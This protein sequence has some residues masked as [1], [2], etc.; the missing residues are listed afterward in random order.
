M[1]YVEGLTLLKETLKQLS[2]LTLMFLASMTSFPPA[3]E[4][5]TQEV[6]EGSHFSKTF[7]EQRHYRLIL[8]RDY[9]T[10][11]K[12][13]PVIYYFH[14]HSGRFKGEQYGDG[15]VFLP[16]MIDF[17][18]RHDVVIVRWDGR[19]E[20]DYDGFYGGTPYDIQG[21]GWGMDFG[22][23]FLELVTHIDKTYRTLEDRSHR[24]TS[25]LSMGGFMSLY[26]SARFPDLVGSA[27]A[28]NPAHENHVGPEGAKVLYKHTDHV[29][30][31]GHSKVRLVRASGDYISQHHDELRDVYSRTPGVDFEYRRDE[32]HRHWVT[33]VDETFD[34]H[35]KAFD[36]AGLLAHPKNWSYD[37]A[38]PE[39][40]VWGYDV[41]VTNKKPGY[42]CL[43][44]VGWG[45]FRVFTRQYAPD[46]PPVEEQ[47]IRITTPEYYG[48]H[49]TY[50]ILDYSHEKDRVTRYELVS[51]AGGELVFELDG[52]GHDIA[53]LK[54]RESR[55]PVLLPW[56]T[57]GDPV[58]EPDR[59][60]LLPIRLINT[61]GIAVK[62]VVVS[63]SS[64]YP[65]VE[66]KGGPVT[67]E[68][69]EPGEIIDL[70]DRFT[71]H[72]VSS[73][74]SFQHCRLNLAVKYRGWYS[75][76]Y[77]VDARILPTPLREPLGV[78]VIDGRRRT[79]PIFRQAGNQGGG[80]MLERE[81][82]EGTGNGDGFADPGEAVSIWIKLLQG[83][84]PFDK[85]SWHRTKIYTDDACVV[86][87]EDVAEK[88]GREFTSVR[89][90][91][92]VIRISPDCPAGHKIRLFLK[93]ESYSFVWT[94]DMRYGKEPL[95]QATQRYR[96]HFHQYELVVGGE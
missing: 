23:Y 84:V 21:K 62:N 77:N 13:Y 33:S 47:I 26:V 31:H 69:I 92:S 56:D 36:D 14:G 29:L 18:R 5:G 40:S 27:S 85:N 39:F 52:R 74:G 60:L 88:K 59:D 91:T 75:K 51:T 86:S 57:K 34:F 49:Q 53:I 78:E 76:H 8:P 6:I 81:V 94:P 89:D 2:R 90:H 24:A 50:Q 70:S 67:V 10:S 48:S 22:A 61:N 1:F 3:I 72:F 25:G 87:F 68:V 83:M 11:G 43:R 38:Y 7:G 28:F 71:E 73:E 30:N 42:V 41:E 95:Y 45:Y 58:V 12:Y 44:D 93:N 37:N 4:A 63:F 65:I 54:E 55:A 64:D 82:E 35:M 46:G 15:Q 32:Y 9:E 80:S 20:E 17:V 16:E 19:V 96:D 66:V 79:F